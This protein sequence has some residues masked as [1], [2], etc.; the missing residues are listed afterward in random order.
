MCFNGAIAFAYAVRISKSG[1]TSLLHGDQL[2]IARLLIGAQRH[3]Y[4]L[5]TAQQ[6]LHLQKQPK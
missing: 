6:P 2:G 4:R 3:R 1:V 5:G